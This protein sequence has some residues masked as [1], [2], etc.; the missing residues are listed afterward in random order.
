MGVS[1]YSY[2]T[3]LGPVTFAAND[4]GLTHAVFGEE[5]AGLPASTPFKPCTFT[6]QAATELLEY[7]AGKRR[8]FSVPLNPTGSDFQQQVWRALTRI[9]YA[10]ALTNAQLAER[11]GMKGSHRSVGAAVKKNPLAVF[12]PDHRVVAASGETLGTGET[13]RH[14][15]MLLAFERAQAS[16]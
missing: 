8:R 7:L 15:A 2:R 3:P 11:M 6:N 16:K 14:H 4:K 12:V 9:P 13:A 5:I 1:Y 10:E